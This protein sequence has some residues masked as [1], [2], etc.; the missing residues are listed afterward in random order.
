MEL[1][2]WRHAEAE[3]GIPDMQRALTPKGQKQARNMASW[4]VPRLPED[5]LILASPSKRTQ[6]T[7]LA[8]GLDF[9]TLDVL[10]PD[11][12][13]RAVLQAAG[14]PHGDRNV[15]VIGHQPTLGEVASIMLDG[16]GAGWSI[17]KGA[18]WWFSGRSRHGLDECVLR[19]VMTPD[20]L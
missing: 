12:S 3:D 17:R 5:T 18:V 9:T 16:Q 2:L 13:P 4:L 14:W 8:L 19:A 20:L 15:L 7:A 11:A 6:Q 1:I 10:A